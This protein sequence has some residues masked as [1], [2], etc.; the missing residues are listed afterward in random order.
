[1]AADETR[2]T[3]KEELPDY[4]PTQLDEQST[5]LSQN[6]AG[7]QRPDPSKPIARPDIRDPL[8]GADVGSYEIIALL[9]KGG[10]AKVYRARD[11]TL[12]RDVA[13]KFLH[14]VVDPRRQALFERE[15]KA[16]AALSKHPNIIAIH[17]WGEHEGQNYVVL[18][19]VEGSA[20]K[21]LEEHPEGLPLALA[22]R[23]GAECAEA[24]QEAHKNKILHRDIKPG[25]ILIEPSNGAVKL[26]DFGLA[27]FGPSS[28]FTIYGTVSGSPSY[29][30]PE[31]A[32]AEP[33]DA[34]TD[35]FSLGVALYEL[36]C[37]K[38]PFDADR[39]EDTIARIRS[40]D[41]ILLRTRRPDLPEAVCSIVEKATAFARA[42]RYQTAQEFARA[43]RIALQS[44]ERSGKVALET[45]PGLS[46]ASDE[47]Q[48]Q[49]KPRR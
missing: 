49:S 2:T 16:I 48:K 34:R 19:L 37:G 43:L 10:F 38:L 45:M 13:I 44:L 41:R 25:N 39:P 12:G 47:L 6:G 7:G 36:L 27:S 31:Q 33:L 4:E 40:N 3:P 35:I 15:A 23:I 5:V 1:M 24:L 28:D 30:S 42:S 29:M 22:L 9:G 17:Q 26:T 21:L 14:N 18:E 46:T 20:E 8:L 32:N 11:K